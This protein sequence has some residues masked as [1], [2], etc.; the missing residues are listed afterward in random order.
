M[1]KKAKNAE[2]LLAG[3]AFRFAPSAPEAYEQ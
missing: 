3:K 2:Q 1:I